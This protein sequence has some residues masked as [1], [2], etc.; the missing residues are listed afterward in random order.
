MTSINLADAYSLQG[1]PKKALRLLG[2]A[3]TFLKQVGDLEGLSEVDFNMAL[4]QIEIGNEKKALEYF[5][6]A[7]SF[8]LTYE[9]KLNERRE[10]F[11]GRSK[12]KFH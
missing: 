8:P 10:V 5:E 4:V 6:R 1:N 12:E 7:Q 9:R 2:K 3:R 11:E